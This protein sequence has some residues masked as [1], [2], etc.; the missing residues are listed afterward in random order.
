MACGVPVIAGNKDGSTE[1]L[2]FGK[3]GSL[4]DPDNESELQQAIAV[5][6]EKKQDP[7]QCQQAMLT[8]FAFDRFCERLKETFVDVR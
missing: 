7:L 5:V 1:A 8:C 4:I 6:L 2:Q 3:L